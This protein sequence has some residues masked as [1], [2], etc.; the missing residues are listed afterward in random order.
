[1]REFPQYDALRKLPP[2]VSLVAERT[3]IVAGL[4]LMTLI[5]VVVL[6]NQLSHDDLSEKGRPD[7]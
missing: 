7:A 2:T 5:T 6:S 3:L 4:F 1:L